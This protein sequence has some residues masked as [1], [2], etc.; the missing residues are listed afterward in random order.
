[1]SSWHREELILG[2]FSARN[3]LSAAFGPLASCPLP[4]SCL[5]FECFCLQGLSCQSHLRAETEKIRKMLLQS[6]SNTS[7]R[8]H[9]LV[10]T[11]RWDGSRYHDCYQPQGQ[12]GKRGWWPISPTFEAPFWHLVTEW[13]SGKHTVVWGLT[14]SPS[15]CRWEQTA[16]MERKPPKSSGTQRGILSQGKTFLLKSLSIPIK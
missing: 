15:F 10:S 12:N 9:H 8:T 16:I 13:L 11:G 3:A 5:W 2:F 4:Y 6:S 1:M 14:L 7:T